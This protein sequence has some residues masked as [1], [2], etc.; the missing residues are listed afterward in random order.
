VAGYSLEAERSGEGGA[1]RS[2]AQVTRF[3]WENSWEE[4][5]AESCWGRR[6]GRC[7]RN[8]ASCGSVVGPGVLRC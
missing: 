6:W 1:G 7:V 2:I 3:G 4:E 8:G 5:V